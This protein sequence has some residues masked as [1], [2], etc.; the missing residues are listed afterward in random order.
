[1]KANV[2]TIAAV[3]AAIFVSGYLTVVFI[4]LPYRAIRTAEVETQRRV[5]KVTQG[6]VDGKVRSMRNAMAVYEANEEQLSRLRSDASG[7]GA[8]I[9]A[10]MNQNDGK[11]A[12]IRNLSDQIASDAVPDDVR[13]FL[14]THR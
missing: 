10:L 14:S 4:V 9:D 8:E 3:I 7:H 12:E 11:L 1:M 6:Y 5:T 2:L 13:R